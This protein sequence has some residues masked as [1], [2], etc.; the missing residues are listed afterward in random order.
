MGS[1]EVSEEGR[2]VGARCKRYAVEAV[3]IVGILIKVAAKRTI[4][5]V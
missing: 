3:T 5:A 1:D 2:S 4:L